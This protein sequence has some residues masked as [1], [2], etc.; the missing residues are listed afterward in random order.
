MSRVERT[1]TIANQRGLHARA[2]SKFVTLVSELDTE[3][4]VSRDGQTV[5]GS[6]ILDLMMLGA[7]M[8]D[9]ITIAGEGDGAEKAVDRLAEL[10]ESKFGED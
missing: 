1:V 6:S 3:I 9:T 2:S 8:G 4:Q 10:V 5:A 7:A